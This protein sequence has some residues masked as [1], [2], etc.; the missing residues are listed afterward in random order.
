M[1]SHRDLTIQIILKYRGWG[2]PALASLMTCNRC[3]TANEI[4]DPPSTPN[5]LPGQCIHNSDI[6]KLTSNDENT[7]VHVQLPHLT[8]CP[9]YGSLDLDLALFLDTQTLC[10]SFLVYPLFHSFRES[11]SDPDDEGQFTGRAVVVSTRD[12]GSCEGMGL[13]R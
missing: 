7:I 8:I 10:S 2:L 1:D 6:A 11:I 4:P 13:P 5:Q 12:R 3:A 9:F